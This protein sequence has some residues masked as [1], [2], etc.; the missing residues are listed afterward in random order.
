MSTTPPASKAAKQQSNV[1]GDA[2]ATSPPLPHPEPGPRPSPAVAALRAELAAQQ[3]ITTRLQEE[4]DFLRQIIDLNPHFMFAKDRDGRFTFANQALAAAY[5]VTADEMIGKTDADF[6]PHLDETEHFRRDDLQVM[7]SRRDKFIAAE[8]ISDAAGKRRWLQTIKRAIVGPDGVAN[9]VL[10][11]ATDITD[12][13][14]LEQQ[15]Q[16][17]LERRS[18]QVRLSTHIAQEIAAAADLKELYRRVVVQVKEQFGYYYAQLLRYDPA[19]DTVVLVVGY[20]AAGEQ[21][22]AMHHSMPVGV[23]LIG[24]AAATGRAILRPDVTEAR[25]GD[26][27][28]AA[29]WRPNPLLPLTKGELAV[30]I[31]LGEQILGVLDVQ[32]DVAG[33]LDEDDQLL[34]EGLCGQIAIAIES[35]RLRQEMESRLMELSALQRHLSRQGW[36]SYQA[37]GS[38][39]MGY[40]FD[41]GDV[42]PLSRPPLPAAAIGEQKEGMQPTNPSPASEPALSAGKESAL[43]TAAGQ[44]QP[45]SA[46]EAA[47]AGVAATGR[48]GNGTGTGTGPE[49]ERLV[50]APLAVRGQ[51]VGTLGVHVDSGRPIS[52]EEEAFLASVAE[53]VAEALEAARLFEQT[54][55]ALAEQERLA[56]ELETVAKVSTAASTLLD[57]N[58]LLQSVVDLTKSSFALYHAHV[59]LIDDSGQ[60]LVLAAGAGEVGR[61]MTLEGREIPL[62]A[63]SLVARAA[64]G[65]RG[66]IENDVRK[67]IDFLPHP[68]LPGTRSELAVPMIVGTKVVGVLDLQSDRPDTFTEEDLQ[69]YKT[70]AAQIAVAVE[71]ARQY[72]AQVETA[73]KLRQVD[74]LKSEFLASMS[75][76]LRTPL[77]SI[78]GFADVLLEG[79][80]GTLNERME[81]DVR[82][83]RESGRHLRELIGDILDMSKIESGRMELRT[84]EID[85]AQMANDIRA[86]AQ[87][88]AQEKGLALHLDLGPDLRT[89]QADRTRLRQILWNIMG[90]AIKFTRR[91]SITLAM[92]RQGDELLVSIRD[93]GIGIK[94]EDI[95]IVFEQFRQIDGSLN[96][97][98]GGTGLG[99]PITKK[100][101]ELHGG[102]IWVE[103]APG[104]GSTFSFTIPYEPQ[105]PKREGGNKA[106]GTS[107][108]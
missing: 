75:H 41:H 96:R 85:L 4:R 69:I 66:V 40:E 35:T 14:H 61:L 2:P 87:P 9:H 92:K 6:N 71:N 33:A 68:L 84:E 100:L 74:E 106:Q 31:K 98:S 28:D 89:I 49:Q 77:N 62:Q 20:G 102:K 50:Q 47:A 101:V 93:T 90:N 51:V 105:L 43:S 10:G 76:E 94:A 53:E 32:S 63:G 7:D 78:I 1:A 60:R 45:G 88:L 19:L 95:P 17:S 13:V 3:A 38:R 55:N 79:L 65:R 97:S 37:A 58:V 59:Y 18:R 57:V 27:G 36:D 22:L 64:R 70:L 44:A 46:P 15:V 8:P 24:T 82:L 30:P 91:G 67:T 73:L 103:S 86:T 54:Q 56:A 83:I 108:K 104:H 21:M 39:A 72:E 11:V 16:A 12:R 99:M 107:N 42:Q 25:D 5:G 23:G 34:L 48:R 81:E 52:A 80:D 26:Q 29:Q